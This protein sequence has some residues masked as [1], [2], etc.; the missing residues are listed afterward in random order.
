ME[1]D[2]SAEWESEVKVSGHAIGWMLCWGYSDTR[3]FGQV[4]IKSWAQHSS[5]KDKKLRPAR[6]VK[7][8]DEDTPPHMH[9]L[10]LQD[11]YHLQCKLPQAAAATVLLGGHAHPPPG[12][13]PPAGQGWRLLGGISHCLPDSR[14]LSSTN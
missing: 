2:F 7:E 3:G 8:T 11:Q 9:Y 14:V 5:F 1:N 6:L 4:Q 13:G 10:F 12:L